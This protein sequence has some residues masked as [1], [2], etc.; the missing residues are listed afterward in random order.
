LVNETAYTLDGIASRRQV[1]FPY[2]KES[3]GVRQLAALGTAESRVGG[4]GMQERR[5][6][7]ALWLDALLGW[8]RLDLGMRLPGQKKK[9]G[10]EDGDVG[11]T[12]RGGGTGRSFP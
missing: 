8:R 5:R 12:I 2:D 4:F 3:N 9:D 6:S 7:G 11:G 1:R 10:G